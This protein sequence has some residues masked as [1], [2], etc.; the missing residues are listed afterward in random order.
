MGGNLSYRSCCLSRENLIIVI[1]EALRITGK[2]TEVSAAPKIIPEKF[3][4]PKR[5]ETA[6]GGDDESGSQ[7]TSHNLKHKLAKA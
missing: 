4:A 6:K 5:A 3:C 2:S 1:V 7:R